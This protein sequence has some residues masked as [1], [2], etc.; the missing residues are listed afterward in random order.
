M[1]SLSPPHPPRR[2][3]PGE[4]EVVRR[5][6]RVNGTWITRGRLAE[7]ADQFLDHLEMDRPEDLILACERALH[8]AQEA[9]RKM[10]DPKLPFYASLFSV[11]TREE[12]NHFLKEHLFTRLLSAE[13]Q[14][15]R[16]KQ[17]A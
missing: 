4:E 11:A 12:R 14:L 16:M 9:S 13:L 5:V 1:A 8:A 15:A 6:R 7:H 17:T 2:S 3:F 10:S